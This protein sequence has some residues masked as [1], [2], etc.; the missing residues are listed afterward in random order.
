MLSLLKNHP[1]AVTSHFNT[2]L[3]LTFAVPKDQLQKLIPT[4]LA[5]DTY[6]NEWAFVAV[7]MVDASNL[8]PTG[9]PAFLGN[10]FILTGYR[11][12]VQYR[13]S[14]GKR[15]RGL[16]IIRSET[17]NA[18]M[19]FFGNLFT[20][21]NYRQTDISFSRQNEI[22]EV[23]SS[24]SDL[25][26]KVK[27]GDRDISLPKDSPFKDWKEARRYAGPLPFTFTY[28][29]VK[30]EVLIIEGVRD[31]WAPK[32]VEVLK[33]RVGFVDSLLLNGVVLANAFVV[34]NIPYS[35]KKGRID[36]WIKS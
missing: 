19:A 5:L 22:L 1:F 3:V 7:A 4:C 31:D 12:F 16:Y 21:Y 2:S 23:K 25:F 15:L 34:N 14:Y 33:C 17:D 27:L 10:D 32:P 24:A 20:H 9:F 29:A 11:I 28:D 18:R 30:N 35:W 26:V 36:P 8:R 13:T 6:A